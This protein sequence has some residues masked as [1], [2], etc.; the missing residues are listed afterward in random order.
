M[1]IGCFVIGSHNKY[2]TTDEL[3]NFCR[4]FDVHLYSEK[5]AVIYANQSYLFVH[6]CSEGTL[7]LNMPESKH[8]IP[9]M[10]AESSTDRFPAKYGCLFE[11]K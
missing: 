10:G 4:E 8:L 3:R 11:I 1:N 5:D 6:T 9:I 2:V 7:D